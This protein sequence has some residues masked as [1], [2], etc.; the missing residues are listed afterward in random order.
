MTLRRLSDCLVIC[1][2]YR[3]LPLNITA[4]V[5]KHDKVTSTHRTIALRD[6]LSWNYIAS[7]GIAGSRNLRLEM[8]VQYSIRNGHWLC[9]RSSRH[10]SITFMIVAPEDMVMKRERLHLSHMFHVKHPSLSI[11]FPGIRLHGSFNDSKFIL[12]KQNWQRIMR[13]ISGK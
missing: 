9:G 4:C 13:H 7:P 8:T 11:S 10:W 1:S 5:W 12:L 2:G 3:K 6:N